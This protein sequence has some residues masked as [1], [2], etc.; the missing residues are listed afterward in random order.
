M[1]TITQETTRTR[2]IALLRLWYLV[3]SWEGEGAGQ[4]ASYRLQGEV[5]WALKDHYLALEVAVYDESG[6][7]LGSEHG[8]IHYDRREQMLVAWFFGSDGRAERAIGW[9]D[10]QGRLTLT[11]VQITNASPEFPARFVRRIL[12][13]VEQGMWAYA[14]EVD[15]GNGV[16]P[17]V[18]GRMYRQPAGLAGP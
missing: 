13:P 17:F 3:G 2:E 14:I 15:F 8:Y 16:I 10:A 6:Q 18:H 12:W 1:E 11:T 9:A 4:G 5:R 7:P